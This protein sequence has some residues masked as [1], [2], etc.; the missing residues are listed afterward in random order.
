M[1]TESRPK[2]KHESLI[3]D[4]PRRLRSASHRANVDI[5]NVDV[6]SS[7]K[8][9]HDPDGDEFNPDDDD[10][11]SADSNDS[12][13]QKSYQIGPDGPWVVEMAAIPSKSRR[14]SPTPPRFL[15]LRDCDRADEKLLDQIDM[16]INTVDKVILCT[17][18][19]QGLQAA[20]SRH[21]LSDG[22]LS[23]L[24]VPPNYCPRRKGA[25][26]SESYN[27][28]VRSTTL[29]HLLDEILERYELRDVDIAEP[30]DRIPICGLMFEPGVE[31]KVCH[32]RRGFSNQRH[33]KSCKTADGSS[34]F[35]P[36]L[37]QSRLHPKHKLGRYF[38]VTLPS[39]LPIANAIDF[40]LDTTASVTPIPKLPAI[41]VCQNV[42]WLAKVQFP[43]LLEAEIQYSGGLGDAIKLVELIPKTDARQKSAVPHEWADVRVAMDG[44]IKEYIPKLAKVDELL[45][46]KLLVGSV[47]TTQDRSYGMNV[48]SLPSGLKYSTI[49]SRI[50]A[51]LMRCRCNDDLSRSHQEGMTPRTELR[52]AI[53][54]LID[55]VQRHSSISIIQENIVDVLFALINNRYDAIEPHSIDPLYRCMVYLS[56]DPD[57]ETHGR[58]YQSVGHIAHNFSAV[59]WVLRLAAFARIH[60]IRSRGSS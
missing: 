26:L 52:H 41:N 31:C 6:D 43:T 51:Y 8:D 23:H 53:S 29:G 48:I 12:S 21:R 15:E 37:L 30:D 11:A 5:D 35:F 14:G 60:R 40:R 45:R 47:V 59:Q 54:H 13:K 2:R 24:R 9:N 50:I 16:A 58:T 55:S 7:D 38:R 33:P 44:F 4:E 3:H 1:V 46:Q 42:A 18:C 28:L 10:G 20:G 57:R 39:L 34:V 17:L 36:I 22:M 49:A 19:C 32:H 25:V 27:A 56:I